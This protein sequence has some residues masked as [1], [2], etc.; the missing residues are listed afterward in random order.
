VPGLLPSVPWQSVLGANMHTHIY[1]LMDLMGGHSWVWCGAQAPQPSDARL[2]LEAAGGEILAVAR[3]E[4]SA[5][6][7]ATEAAVAKLRRA[8]DAGGGAVCKL[9]PLDAACEVLL[10]GILLPQ[11]AC[12]WRMRRH[13]V[14][15]DWR[16]TGP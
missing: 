8:L 14:H 11:M 15:S 4:G 2:S 16:S 12:G 1:T 7:E 6:R 5:T 9:M 13:K 10:S 3:F